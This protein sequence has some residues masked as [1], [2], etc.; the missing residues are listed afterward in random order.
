MVRVTDAEGNPLA[1]QT[2]IF[3]A[4]SGSVVPARGLTDAEGR[5]SVRWT[6]GPKAKRPELGATVAG[7]K[8]TRSLAISARP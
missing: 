1:G 7:T 5:A 2:I 6:L 4:T 8:V 3:K